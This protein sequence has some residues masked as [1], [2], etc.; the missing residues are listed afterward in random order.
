MTNEELLREV[1]ALP[2][3]AQRQVAD[4]IM[5]LRERYK[6]PSE[7]SMQPKKDIAEEEAIGMWADRE[8]MKD[9]AQWVRDLRRS[10]AWERQK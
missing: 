10:S 4:F 9:S 1:T 8:D 3:D 7:D 5:F 6:S 2:P